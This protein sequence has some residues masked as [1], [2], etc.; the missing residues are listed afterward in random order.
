[1]IRPSGTRGRKKSPEDPAGGV[2][3]IT[4]IDFVPFFLEIAQV[5]LYEQATVHCVRVG[6]CS[7]GI[8]RRSFG[9]AQ[10]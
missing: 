10:E 7:T 3:W 9:A 2:P 5:A 4:K 8:Q 1:M 6:P